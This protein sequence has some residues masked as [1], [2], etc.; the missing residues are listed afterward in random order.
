MV[1]V[2]TCGVGYRM[3]CCEGVGMKDNT[4]GYLLRDLLK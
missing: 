2:N 3:E 4:C 1:D